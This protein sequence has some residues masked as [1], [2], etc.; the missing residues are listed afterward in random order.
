MNNP[1]DIGEVMSDHGKVPL[2]KFFFRSANGQMF[3]VVPGPP[4]D[5]IN[6]ILNPT[7]DNT[8]PSK[9]SGQNLSLQ[10]NDM[11][12]LNQAPTSKCQNLSSSISSLNL[13]LPVDSQ[14]LC[15]PADS[16]NLGMPA[17]SQNLTVR[18]QNLDISTSSEDFMPTNSQIL[19]PAS[20]S[21]NLVPSH[22][23][24]NSAV[25]P[26]VKKTVPFKKA[27]GRGRSKKQFLT[28][29]DRISTDTH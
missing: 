27:K 26:G 12:D 19:T 1:I 16:Q 8:F 15:L 13:C 14:S 22:S 3:E 24:S 5:A 6:S 17:N 21:E 7:S 25:L 20:S 2:K 4:T 18:S 23:E 9:V 11:R 29:E 28:D 10:P